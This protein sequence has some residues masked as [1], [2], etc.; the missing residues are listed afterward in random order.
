MYV[1]LSFRS[2]SQGGGGGKEGGVFPFQ[3]LSLLVGRTLVFLRSLS[4]EGEVRR[5][6]GKPGRRKNKK[7][8]KTKLSKKG[9]KK[10]HDRNINEDSSDYFLVFLFNLLSPLSSNIRNA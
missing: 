7:H 9:K 6:D 5:G 3:G 10:L 2:C 8:L 4:V 1:S